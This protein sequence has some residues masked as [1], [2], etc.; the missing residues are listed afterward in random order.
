MVLPV[1]WH[2]SNRNALIVCDLHADPSPLWDE[3]GETLRRRLY[4]RREELAENELPT[5]L[6]LVHV[7]RCPVL[8]PSGSPPSGVT[9]QNQKTCSRSSP[10]IQKEILA[11][12]VDDKHLQNLQQGLNQFLKLYI[13]Q[14]VADMTQPQTRTGD[15][16]MTIRTQLFRVSQKSRCSQ[17]GRS[18]WLSCASGL[19]PLTE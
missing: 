4:T 5:P 8:A 2:P 19:W 16:K 17:W 3:S 9:Q 14:K 6:K 13:F 10:H 12:A 15:G 7:N 11:P 1:A 18:E